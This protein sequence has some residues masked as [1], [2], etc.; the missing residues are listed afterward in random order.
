VAVPCGLRTTLPSLGE[1]GRGSAALVGDG[2]VVL[3]RL[4]VA[5]RSVV[6]ASVPRVDRLPDVPP[7]LVAHV[8]DAM[9]LSA[10]AA[11]AAADP[12]AVPALLGRG[13]GLTPLG[14]DVLAGWIAGRQAT[15]SRSDAVAAEVRRLAPGRTTL[16]SATL[17]DCALR[18]DVLPPVRAWLGSG[19]GLDAVLAVGGTSGAGLALGLSLAAAPA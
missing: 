2:R 15:G 1:V 18:G 10:L 8:R 7:R 4:E 17:L 9:P 16:L 13:E 6:D 5:L 19:E 14:D 12:S 11:L 3:G